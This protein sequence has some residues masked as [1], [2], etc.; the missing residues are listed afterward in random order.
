MFG[1]FFNEVNITTLKVTGNGVD[2]A[3]NG[4][5]VRLDQQTTSMSGQGKSFDCSII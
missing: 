2:F 5:D 1:S 3:L 4:T